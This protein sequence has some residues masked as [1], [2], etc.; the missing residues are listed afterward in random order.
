MPLEVPNLD[1]RRWADLVADAQA[2]IPREAPRWTDHN[3]HDPGITF[4]EL[5]AWLAEMQIYQLNRVGERHREVFG[6][7]ANV[8]RRLR[9]PARVQIAAGQ[10]PAVGMTLPEGTQLVPLEG[11]ELVFETITEMRLTRTTLRQVIVDDGFGPIDQTN[12]NATFGATFLAFG[13]QARAGAELRLGF[14]A[15]YPQ[16]DRNIRV[17]LDVLTADLEARCGLAAPVP[18]DNGEVAAVSPV[19]LV[20]EYLGPGGQWIALNV[21]GDE[22]MALSRSGAVAL[23]TPDQAAQDRGLVWIRARIVRGYYDIEPRLRQV[24]L[25]VLPCVQR[26][27]VRDEFVGSG[28]GRPDQSYELAKGPIL[29]HESGPPLRIEVGDEEWEHVTSFDA[30]TP[31]STQFMFDAESRRVLFGNGLNGRV[32][33]LGE[34]VRALWYQTSGGRSGNVAKGLTWKFRALA[35]PGVSLRNPSPAIG[36]ADL[37]PLAEMELRARAQLNRPQRAVTLLDIERLALSTPHAHVAR[38]Y[39]IPNCPTP[40][41]ITVVVVPK[42]RP[43][44]TGPPARPSDAFLA[45]VRRH[46]EERR[47]LCDNLR[48]LGPIYVEVRVAARLRLAKG[49]GAAAVI[50]RATN[51]LDRFFSGEDA[52]SLDQPASADAAMSPC[53]TRWPF[54]RSVFPS[55]V[56]AVLDGVAGVD[57]ASDVVLSARRN[58]VPIAADATG[59][60]PVPRIGLVFAGP[61][62]LVVDAEPPRRQ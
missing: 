59:A 56:Y 43:G 33:A 46:L 44:R 15:F 16:Q 41:R 9:T 7:L 27:T 11:D 53:P 42:I 21:E 28:N 55:D 30:A 23:R 6:R 12:A 35:V 32:P 10:P 29:L 34:N 17:S 49:A 40:G 5:F 57:A 45:A 48:V 13:E 4:I 19:D 51:T 36:G 62:D 50:V 2:L 31:D 58:G 37:E 61:H 24:A 38:A 54:G 52:A 25:N 26:E 3:V 8:R 20:W 60:I 39:A 1:D 47:L 14:D 18:S 22:S